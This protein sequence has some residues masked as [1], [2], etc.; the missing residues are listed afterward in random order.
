MYEHKRETASGATARELVKA[1]SPPSRHFRHLTSQK[2][3]VGQRDNNIRERASGAT[4]QQHARKSKWGNGTTTYENPW[5]LTS[6]SSSPSKASGPKLPSPIMSAGSSGSSNSSCSWNIGRPAASSCRAAERKPR[7]PNCVPPA[8]CASSGCGSTRGTVRA[9]LNPAASSALAGAS[10]RTGVCVELEPAAAPSSP[11][12]MRVRHASWLHAV[13][14][15]QPRCKRP[16][17]QRKTWA[18]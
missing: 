8:S 9:A 5:T 18:A 3:E 6:R 11:W 13:G 14:I 4:G 16:T 12:R 15:L 10:G 7:A 1:L 2:E 17:T